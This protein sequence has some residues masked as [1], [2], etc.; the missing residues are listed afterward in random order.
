MDVLQIVLPRDRTGAGSLPWRAQRIG[1]ECVTD[2]A[3]ARLPPRS[4]G[5]ALEHIELVAENETRYPEPAEIEL[6]RS[7]LL[8]CLC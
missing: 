1:S 3:I 8:E 5:G 4:P 6:G 7:Q 2:E